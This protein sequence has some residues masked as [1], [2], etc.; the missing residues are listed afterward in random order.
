MR[1]R[2]PTLVALAGA[3]LIYALP[4]LQPLL[5]YDREA[6]LAGDVWRLF[7]GHWVHFSASHLGF[8]LTALAI[9]GLI[10]EN[11]RSAGW[12]WV[13]L[14]TPWM[15]GVG[16]LGCEPQMGF[17]GGLSGVATAAMVC[18]ALDA[19][20]Q[21]SPVRWVGMVVLALMVAKVAFEWRTE[22]ALFVGNLSTGQITSPLSHLIG[23]L[24]GAVVRWGCRGDSQT[25]L[26]RSSTQRRMRS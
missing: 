21:R 16:L 25:S 8:N 20:Q 7:T 12:P 1:V 17:Y 15:I 5:I 11:Q 13:L 4:Q 19:F 9:A 24:S 10:L 22:H 23:G 26:P 2:S 18:L 6:I 3:V 14:F